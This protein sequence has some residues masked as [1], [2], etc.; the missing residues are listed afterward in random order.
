MIKIF[1]YL[2]NPQCS[3]LIF[4]AIF[5]VVVTLEVVEA[6]VSCCEVLAMFEWDTGKLGACV[7]RLL[8][9]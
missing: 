9:G 4:S 3:R 8:I 6:K 7:V 1:T 2:K 5:T